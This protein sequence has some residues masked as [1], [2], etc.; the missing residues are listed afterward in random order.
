MEMTV[1]VMLRRSRQPVY[2]ACRVIDLDEDVGRLSRINGKL[3]SLS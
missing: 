2:N 1:A 3:L